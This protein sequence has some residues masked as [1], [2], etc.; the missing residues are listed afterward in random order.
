MFVRYKAQTLPDVYKITKL[1]FDINFNAQLKFCT[2]NKME[3]W[4]WILGWILSI[5]TVAGNGFTVLLV[6]GQPRLRTK[7]KALIVSLAVADFCVGAFVVPSLFFCDIRGGCNWPQ[8]YASWVDFIR[9]LFA[10]A[11]IMNL[12]S[13]VLDRIVLS[14]CCALLEIFFSCMLIFCSISMA[15]VV[16][17]QTRSS[18]ILAKQLRFNHQGLTFNTYDKSAVVM[19]AVVVVFALACFA[20][21]L[22]CSFLQLSGNRRHP[23]LS[24]KSDFKFR[25]PMLVLNSAI[26]PLAYAFFK[27]D[28]KKALKGKKRFLMRLIDLNS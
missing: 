5:L 28:I 10:Y 23:H 22:R 15:T 16:Y 12:S 14:V 20:T 26:N 13:L 8:P 18:A 3:T 4:F 19:L 7:T 17:K 27:H 21:Y 2:D 11:S 25:I 24:C 9:W 6:R 1:F